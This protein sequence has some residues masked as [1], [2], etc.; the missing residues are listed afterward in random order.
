VADLTQSTFRTQVDT[1]FVLTAPDETRMR[2]RLVEVT[3][4]RGA[5]TDEEG[6]FSL[7]FRGPADL[8][9]PQGTYQMAHDGIG[10]FALFIVPVKKDNDGVYYEAIFNRLDP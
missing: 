7:L 10:T 6:R 4:L 5:G 3:G 9:I 8:M 1:E 2:I